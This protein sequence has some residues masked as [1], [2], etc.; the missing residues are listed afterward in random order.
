[1]SW[2][3]A[4]Y[5]QRLQKHQWFS[6]ASPS[7]GWGKKAFGQ[8]V[9]GGP[10]RHVQPSGRADGRQCRVFLLHVPAQLF[11]PTQILN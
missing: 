5:R 3:E 6:E 11:W 4:T 2:N 1:M 10:T 8:Q 7:L 9:G